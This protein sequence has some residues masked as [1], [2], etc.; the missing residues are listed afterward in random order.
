M[1]LYISDRIDV[2]GMWIVGVTIVG[3]IGYLMLALIENNDTRYGAVWLVV[4]S[5]FAFIPLTYSWLIAN[6]IGETKK[7]LA[8]I[9][10]AT[11]GQ[12]GPLLGT[13]LFPAKEAPYYKRGMFVSAGMLLGAS[14]VTAI[15][16]VALW[17][18]NHRKDVELAR[19]KDSAPAADGLNYQQNLTLGNPAHRQEQHRRQVDITEH[20]EA[21]VYFRYSL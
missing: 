2:R 19:L 16:L 1:L 14:L 12:V 3:A 21:S 4:I 8:L 15:T 17:R 10:F 7:G 13:R 6:S 11:V 18:I 20:R 9:I 5:L